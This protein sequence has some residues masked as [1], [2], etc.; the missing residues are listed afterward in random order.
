MLACCME[1]SGAIIQA[2]LFG[3]L[4]GLVYQMY[5]NQIELQSK[6]DK[7]NG[8]FENLKLKGPVADKSLAY[9]KNCH[10][11]QQK[12]YEMNRFLDALTPSL[13]QTIIAFLVRR[14]TS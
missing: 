3:E 5:E 9:V 13:S 4:A 1:F 2:N 10:N 8:A 7:I 14:I 11:V 12:I 6:I